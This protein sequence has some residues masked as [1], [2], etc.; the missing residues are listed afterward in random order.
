L[1]LRN[2]GHGYGSMQVIVAAIPAFSLFLDKALTIKG[3]SSID[4]E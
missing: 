4:L 3:A 1:I 2:A